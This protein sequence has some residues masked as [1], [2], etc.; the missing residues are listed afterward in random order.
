MSRASAS[1]HHR[2]QGNNIKRDQSSRA[3]DQSKDE[4]SFKCIRMGLQVHKEDAH[5]RRPE[6]NPLFVRV[7]TH[8]QGDVVLILHVP[9]SCHILEENIDL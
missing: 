9:C 2:A 3:G 6:A 8:D 1:Y 4:D 5:G 7:G